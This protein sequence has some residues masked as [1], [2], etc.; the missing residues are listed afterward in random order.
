VAAEFTPTVCVRKAEV[1]QAVMAG[2]RSRA[3]EA[4]QGR[5]AGLALQA[6]CVSDVAA[7]E[8]A[9]PG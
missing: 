8:T 3:D 1:E 4:L 6:K 9:T 7:A 2:D 5:G